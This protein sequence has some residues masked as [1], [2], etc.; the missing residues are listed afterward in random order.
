MTVLK[1][2]EI[3]DEENENDI[4]DDIKKDGFQNWI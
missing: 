3:F 1:A 4:S 2:L